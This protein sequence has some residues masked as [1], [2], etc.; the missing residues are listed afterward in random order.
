MIDTRLDASYEMQGTEK[1]KWKGTRTSN[2]KLFDD[3]MPLIVVDL[4][5]P[6]WKENKKIS[7]LVY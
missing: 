4:N 3:G 5:E 7:F 1:K 2:T 6:I